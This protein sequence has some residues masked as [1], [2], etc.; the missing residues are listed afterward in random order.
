MT[1][2]IDKCKASQ[3]I[4]QRQGTIAQQLKCALRIC[5]NMLIR[6]QTTKSAG[7]ARPPG[8]AKQSATTGPELM[9]S[10]GPSR[11]R[12]CGMNCAAATA[13]VK[14]AGIVKF[15]VTSEF[16]SELAG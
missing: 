5:R 2:E 13:A 6:H 1:H 9:E 14:S 11:S 7:E 8:I 4:Q 3:N 16:E 12:A 10:C 15:S